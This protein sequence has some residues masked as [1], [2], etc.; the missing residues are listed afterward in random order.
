MPCGGRK[1]FPLNEAVLRRR[2]RSLPIYSFLLSSAREKLPGIVKM[3]QVARLYGRRSCRCTI[4]DDVGCEAVGPGKG[5]TNKRSNSMVIRPIEGL[6]KKTTHNNT[7]V[8]VACA[9]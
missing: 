8:E 1:T 5:E 7:I 3:G 6:T 2:S 9:M 4:T